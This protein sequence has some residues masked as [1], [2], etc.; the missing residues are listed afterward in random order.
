MGTGQGADMDDLHEL[1]TQV[2]AA[3]P[4]SRLL[5]ATLS[6][7]GPGCVELSL[8]ITAD[9]S[10]QHGYVH[11]G[12]ISYLADNSITFAGGLT[13]GSDALT[14]EYKINFLAP[15]TGTTLI[16]RAQADSIGER[17]AV[18]RTEIC[19]T[20]G[21]HEQRWAQAQEP[22]SPSPERRGRGTPRQEPDANEDGAS[23]IPP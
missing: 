18:C 4:F 6:S 16:A 1:A 12:V 15:A 21:H 20:D 9:L 22:S 3:Q 13:L 8:P 14:S 10:Q 5:G 17:Q 11:A 19:T 7:V 23:R 2:L